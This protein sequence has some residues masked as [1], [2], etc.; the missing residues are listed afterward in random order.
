MWL[1]IYARLGLLK[2]NARCIHLATLRHTC[3]Q[4]STLARVYIYKYV[5]MLTSS[6]HLAPRTC[7]CSSQELSRRLVRASGVMEFDIRIDS[8]LLPFTCTDIYSLTVMCVCVMYRHICRC[9][10][11]NIYPC[12]ERSFTTKGHVEAVVAFSKRLSF[13]YVPIWRCGRVKKR[14]FDFFLYKSLCRTKRFVIM[15]WLFRA[16]KPR[17]SVAFLKYWTFLTI[18]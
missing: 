13:G 8:E 7:V 11:W 18:F 3:R 9:V 17:G 16:K 5:R 12:C 14:R 4:H 2:G 15:Q 1:C 6:S 10:F